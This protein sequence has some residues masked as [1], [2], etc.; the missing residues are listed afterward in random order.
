MGVAGALISKRRNGIG[1]ALFLQESVF[2][3]SFLKPGSRVIVGLRSTVFNFIHLLNFNLVLFIDAVSGRPVAVDLAVPKEKFSSA[4]VETD[5]TEIK[6]P[7]QLKQEYLLEDTHE[8]ES[9]E[10]VK[11]KEEKYDSES[12]NDD[13]GL[14]DDSDNEV[15]D[16]IED[17]DS[18]LANKK[19]SSDGPSRD[20]AEE[21]T[22]FIK[23]L[24][25][26]ATEEDIGKVLEQYGSLKYVL[27]CIDQMTQHPRG[28][29]FAQFLVSSC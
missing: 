1:T 17:E 23:N 21:R 28:T 24:S 11:I 2:L 10:N 14:E 16:E 4:N 18:T 29:A 25:Y 9:L 5:A 15:E 19:P 6:P 27:L 8:D 7:T 13:S 20:V 26:E 22:L 3:L 12:E